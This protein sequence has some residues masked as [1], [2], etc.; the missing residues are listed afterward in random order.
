[1]LFPRLLQD[2]HRPPR[3]AA[4]P[5]SLISVDS[6]TNLAT[7]PSSSAPHLS[8]IHTWPP[9]VFVRPVPHFLYPSPSSLSCL[10]P[11]A[12]SPGPFSSQFTLCSFTK[13]TFLN[14]SLSRLLSVNHKQARRDLAPSDSSL[15]V[16]LVPKQSSLLLHSNQHTACQ[17]RWPK[18][19]P[20]PHAC[21]PL[22]LKYVLRT[23]KTFHQPQTLFQ[24]VPHRPG[25]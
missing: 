13:G 4:C 12:F 21:K 15:S 20:R 16:Y 2:H 8:H 23:L 25:A 11:P 5:G 6:I 22:P 14:I 18:P 24:Q 7:S 17:K 9:G 19:G 10:T 1:M 3:I